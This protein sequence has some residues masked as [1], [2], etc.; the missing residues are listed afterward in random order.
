MFQ[1]P[2]IHLRT[3]SEYS[4]TDGLIRINELID[5][6][7]RLGQPAVALTD[8]SNIFGL[9]KFYKKSRAMGI[10]PIAGCDVWMSNEHNRQK[11]Y[12]LLI[13]VKNFIGYLELCKL[14]TRSFLGNQF[15]GRPEICQDWLMDKSGLIILSGGRNGDVGHALDSGNFDLALIRAKKWKQMFPDAY[16]IELQRLGCLGDESYVESALN[17]ANIVNLP[18]V[19]THPIQF[20]HKHNFQAHKVRVCIANGTTLTPGSNCKNLDNFTESQYFLNSEEMLQRFSDIPVALKNTVEIAKRCNLLLTLDKYNLPSFP[21]PG[22]ISRDDYFISLSEKGLEGRLKFLFPNPEKRSKWMNRYY[23]RLRQ[24]CAMIIQMGFPGYFL[25]VQDFINWGKKNGVSVGPGRG[26]GAGSLVAY[27]MGI[28]DIDPIRYNLLF[29]RFLNPERVSMPDF[30]IDFCQENRERVIDYVKSKY[31]HEAVSQIVTH[32]TLG[33]KAAIRDTGRALNMPYALCNSLSKLIPFNPT[34]P[35][36]LD[37]ALKDEPSF[38]KRYEE[39]EEVKNLIDIARSL[40]GL[41]RNVGMHAGGILIAPRE[42]TD[43]C[44]LYCQPGQE[45]VSVSQ[46]DKD[47]VE[48]LGLIKFDFLGLRNLTILDRAIANVRLFNETKK[49]FEIT[50]LRLDDRE[51]Y[52]LLSSGNTTAVFQLESR[53]MKDLLRNLRPSSFEDIIAALA[54]YRPGPL[55]SG[56]VDDFINRKHGKKSVDYFHPDLENVLQDTY[57][58]IVYQEQVMLISQIIGGYSLGASDLLRRAMGK[59]KPEEMAKHRKLFEKGAK[60]KGYSAALARRLF[61]LM[62]KFAGYGFNKSHSV[63]YALLAYQTAWLKANHPAEFFAATISSDM[64]DTDKVQ[65]LFCDAQKNGI[66]ILPP[67][68]NLSTFRFEP[69]HDQ[70]TDQGCSPRTI[71]YGL[72]AIKGTG[73]NAVEDILNARKDGPFLNLFDF[74]KR[75][76]KAVNRRTIEALIKSG[77]FDTFSSN[78]AAILDSVQ[79]AINAAGQ[80]VRSKNQRSLFED[81]SAPL[82]E[83]KH[84]NIIPWDLHTKL[85]NEKSALGYYLSGHLFDHWREEI[86][87]IIPVEL[88]QIESK[89]GIQWLCGI[90]TSIRSLITRRGKIILIVLDDSSAQIEVSICNELYEKCRDFLVEDQILAVRGKVVSSTYFDGPRVLAEEIYNFQLM[91]SKNAKSIKVFLDKNIQINDLKN[92]LYSFRGNSD[93]TGVPVDIVYSDGGNKFLCTIRLGEEW[94]VRI[95]DLLIKEL[96]T[97]SYCKNF[98]IQYSNPK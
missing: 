61:D 26:S 96:E 92:L 64:D 94:R 1:I 73:Q 30:D 80:V 71:R 18:V 44:P 16:Y 52:K 5:H 2:F 90:L 69:I 50:S 76:T 68:I 91:R 4:V 35:W 23:S 25:I 82:F 75:I 56:M 93:D 57:G 48:S 21:V 14:L 41:I 15:K 37:R 29:E 77:A 83:E 63:A 54:L 84:D 34:D 66:K 55:E 43:F 72:G 86:R 58:V 87:R 10:K 6:A 97:C 32:G 11:A 9:V 40:E 88:V 51:V 17:L 65:I 31:G 12:R 13:L 42:L 60:E 38:K 79:V 47:D 78:R 45:H 3:H 7:V 36:T 27:S 98:E 95:V 24:E 53:G 62:E 74:C 85:V 49:D 81:S 59:K 67:D 70:Y 20:L 8:L 39:D 33:A 22:E 19:A 28:T 89:P 46:F